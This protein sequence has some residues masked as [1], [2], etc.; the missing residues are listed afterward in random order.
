MVIRTL[1]HL[2][3]PSL[4]TFTACGSKTEAPKPEPVAEAPKAEPAKA[5]PAAEPAKAEP[6]AEPAKAEPVAE[7]VKAEPVAEAPPVPEAKGLFECKKVE[8]PPARDTKDPWGFKYDVP[9]CPAIPSTFG[10]ITFGMDHATAAAAAEEAK[11]GDAKFEGS[12]G[13]IYVGKHPFR[14]QFSVRFDDAGKVDQFVHKIDQKG[15]DLLKATWGE[16][17]MLVDGDDKEFRWYNPENKI[18][19]TAD[20]DSYD[21]ANAETKEDEKVEGY[22]L[23]FAQYAPLADVLGADGLIA[24]A[25]LGKTPDEV[26]AL[27]P[28]L[29][30]VKTAE[31][32]KADLAAVGLDADTQK[33]AEALG[34]ADAKINLRLAPTPSNEHFTLVHMDWEGGKLEGYSFSLDHEKKEDIKNELLAQI[35]ALLGKPTSSKLDDGKAEYTFAGPNGL[36]VRVSPSILE[37]SWKVAVAAK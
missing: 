8:A 34:A 26:K 19:V 16:P 20:P 30:E 21:R 23:R 24:K 2:I 4:I 3:I 28:E 22:R 29:L 18:M 15:F 11:T 13:Y 25:L 36:V 12:S 32:A 10:A 31:Q 35:A 1:R 37:D 6:A 17:V 5:E 27:V 14:T 9:P 7:P 33:K